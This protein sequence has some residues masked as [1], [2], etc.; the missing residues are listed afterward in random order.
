MFEL[1]IKR[2]VIGTMLIF[3]TI[4]AWILMQVVHLIAFV[5]KDQEWITRYKVLHC[6][7]H[8]V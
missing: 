4:H 1:M 2:I 7:F 6:K 5:T 8:R 3:A